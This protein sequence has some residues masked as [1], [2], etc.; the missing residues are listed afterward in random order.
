[1]VYRFGMQGGYKSSARLP[2]AAIRQAIGSMDTTPEDGH[3]SSRQYM[4]SGPR[5]NFGILKHVEWYRWDRARALYGL[6]LAR[7]VMRKQ[8]VSLY[9]T[10]PIEALYSRYGR[11]PKQTMS[12][13]RC[14]ELLAIFSTASVTA[15][16]LLASSARTRMIWQY[17]VRKCS[18]RRKLPR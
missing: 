5:I 12:G 16:S 15:Q 18:C 9:L 3:T 4:L 1:M 10:S 6:N 14:C 8:S 11:S 2:A 13:L 17:L 7:K